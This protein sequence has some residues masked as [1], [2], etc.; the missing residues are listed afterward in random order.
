MEGEV[1]SAPTV[2]D[3]EARRAA[4]DA[5]VGTV[6]GGRFRLD[7]VIGIGGMAAV[8]RAAHRNG[9]RYAIKRLHDDLAANATIAKRFLREGYVANAIDH[10]GVVAIYDDGHDDRG[11]PFL[12]LELLEGETAEEARRAAGG[13]LGIGRALEIAIEILDV[14]VV[15]H[16]KGIVHRDLKPENVFLVTTG[17]PRVRVLDFGL[18]RAREID[19]GSDSL[20]A[21]DCLLGTAGY[22]PPEQASG[23]FARVDARSDLWALAAAIVRLAAGVH[24]HEAANAHERRALAAT[25]PV[26]PIATFAPQIPKEIAAVLDRA[27]A[28]AKPDRWASARAMRAALVRAA[29]AEGFEIAATD[30]LEGDDDEPSEITEHSSEDAADAPSSVARSAAGDDSFSEQ[31]VST[32]RRPSQAPKT[33][34]ATD[35]SEWSRAKW[36]PAALAI[37]ALA[38]GIGRWSRGEES[39]ST[40][41]VAPASTPTPAAFEPQVH[42]APVESAVAPPPPEPTAIDPVS[43][44][45]SAPRPS[46]LAP[47][48]VE[49]RVRAPKP[50]ATASVP[51]SNVAA[52]P[53]VG[54]PNVAPPPSAAPPT[55]TTTAAKD[56][57][58]R[59]R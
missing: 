19:P 49:P 48:V 9:R 28:F 5:S 40:P 22:M 56:P 21:E 34:N 8:F 29:R 16:R 43:P 26:R 3:R 41:A 2:I 59:R 6:L 46:M 55:T 25:T 27:L 11:R 23:R 36:I 44:T 20:T 35:R 42:P 39:K 30:D 7:A 52:A 12:V 33:A 4:A 15:A 38:V 37:A 31:P 13:A 50:P 18:A 24:V 32:A 45:V 1:D 17:D 57:L 54:P 14:L 51:S 47:R 53:S 58:D 10:P